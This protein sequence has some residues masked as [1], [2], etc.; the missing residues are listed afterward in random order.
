MSYIDDLPDCCKCGGRPILLGDPHSDRA[1]EC[2]NVL[3]EKCDNGEFDTCIEGAIWSW[4]ASNDKN[5]GEYLRLNLKRG[6]LLL[7]ENIDVKEQEKILKEM[8][9]IW[10]NLT[11]KQCNLIDW[12]LKKVR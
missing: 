3:E 10:Y 5:M 7:S 6:R 4:I 11:E 12:I 2:E 1:V 9:S 8:D